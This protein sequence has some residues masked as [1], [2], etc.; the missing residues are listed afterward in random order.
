MLSDHTGA[1]D[2]LGEALEQLVEA[3][4]VSHLN[5]HT[6]LSPFLRGSVSDPELFVTGVATV[7]SHSGRTGE[8]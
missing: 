5:T 8:V 6:R 7:M 3:L 1:L 4:G 2:G